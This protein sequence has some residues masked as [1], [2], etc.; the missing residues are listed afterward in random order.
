[1]TYFLEKHVLITGAASGIGLQMVKIILTSK[2]K[3]ITVFDINDKNLDNLKS[4]LKSSFTKLET[5]CVDITNT[6]L[7][8]QKV[9][10]VIKGGNNIDVLINNA[11]I[12][13]G[14]FFKDIEAETI[15]KIMS[16]NITS[17][18]HLTRIVFP[19]LNSKAKIVNIASAAGMVGNP[20]MAVYAASK[21]AVIGWSESL[22]LEFKK[23]KLDIKVI[24]V[25]PFYVKTGMFDGVKSIIPII[26]SQKAAK[27]ILKGVK[28]NRIFVRMPNL[29]Y[30]LPFV[31]GILPVK[32]FD[33][34]V[35]KL[36]GV[37]KSM[38]EFKGRK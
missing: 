33:F 13:D 16:V 7:V 29:I 22:R 14:K 19:Y 24:T 1:M 9:D 11:G 38:D 28:K 31:K 26:S 12:V 17:Y 6:E 8:Q 25:T 35:G 5:V 15:D 4:S 21:W 2:P 20:K 32:W 34:V 3:Q 18:M 30:I 37:Y 36:L 10:E 27:K 23:L